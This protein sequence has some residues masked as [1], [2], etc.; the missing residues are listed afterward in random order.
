MKG[1]DIRTRVRET[2]Q[3]TLAE[4]NYVSAVDVLLGLDWLAPSHVEEWWQGRVPYLERLVQANLSKVSTAMAEFR[5]WARERDLIPSETAYVARTRDRRALRFSVSNDQ[6]ID[7]ASAVA[8]YGDVAIEASGAH[9][10]SARWA[11]LAAPWVGEA[12][13]DIAGCSLG[14][15]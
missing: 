2:E 11:T 14:Q 1:R 8:R 7:R 10:V 3:R 15:R 9:R 13:L 6:G 12:E 4:Q 5:R